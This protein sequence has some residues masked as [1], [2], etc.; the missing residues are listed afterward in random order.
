MVLREAA[1]AVERGHHRY[2]GQIGERD[3]LVGRL[4]VEHP[5][6]GVDHRVGGAQQRLHEVADVVRVGAGLVLGDRGVVERV[7]GELGGGD[8]LGDLQQHRAPA[9]MLELREGP[10]HHLG[11]SLDQIDVC[12]PL[13]DALVVLGRPE[14]GRHPDPAQ[15]LAAG[16]QQYRHRV[17]KGLGDAAEGILHSWAALHGEDT[18]ALAVEDPAVA[19]CHVDTGPLLAADDGPDALFGA[20]FD[21]CLERIARHPLNAFRFQYLRND[22][23]AVHLSLLVCFVLSG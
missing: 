12:C 21:Q 4:G 16:K 8:V 19:V 22:C 5:L 23:V 9:S 1:L 17:C 20:G 6:A 13:G 14:A 15:W 3:Q 10:G 11:D 18:D 2:A 7:A